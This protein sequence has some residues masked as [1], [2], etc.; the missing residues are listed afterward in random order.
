[1]RQI[2]TVVLLLGSLLGVSCGSEQREPVQYVQGD[3][4][5]AE[6]RSEVRTLTSRLLSS[7]QDND[8]A[9]LRELL[10]TEV[11][12]ELDA[13]VGLD[14]LMATLSQVLAESTPQL[15]HEFYVTISEPRPE[16][17]RLVSDPNDGFAVVTDAVSDRAY[18]ALLEAPGG[19]RDLVIGLIYVWRDGAWRLYALRTGTL[20]LAGRSAMDYY[21]EARDLQQRGLLLPAAER[22]A[23]GADLLRPLS[24]MEYVR[25]DELRQ[26]RRGV[27]A[28]MDASH[29]F[30]LELSSPS[31]R[32]RVYQIVPLFLQG[33]LSHV[34]HYVTTLE[35]DADVLEGEVQPMNQELATLFPG[36]CHEI[37][38][39]AYAAYSEPPLD[40]QQNYPS[41]GVVA[42]CSDQ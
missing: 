24:F 17:V 26:L 38:N 6:V 23:V 19:F 36:F 9:L 5:P 37:D 29:S 39:V 28:E 7:L 13:E 22:L 42:S 21:A 1:M 14:R 31:S 27:Q 30:P 15:F 41:V 33:Q 11:R 34:V 4:I 8:P 20:R 32:P 35:L 40:P 10:A 12:E 25:E 16:R 3:E 18:V 2:S